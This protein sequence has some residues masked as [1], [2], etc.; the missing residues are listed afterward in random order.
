MIV[1]VR[2]DG[3]RFVRERHRFVTKTDACP[4][5]IVKSGVNR[6]YRFGFLLQSKSMNGAALS[7]NLD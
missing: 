6:C 3:Q 4:T 1:E 7:R 2:V 5:K